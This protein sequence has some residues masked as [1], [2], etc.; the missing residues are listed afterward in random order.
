VQVR[1]RSGVPLSGHES[2]VP[3]RVPTPPTSLIGRERQVATLLEL[4]RPP[5]G[6]RL[7]VL[8]GPGGVGKTRLAL[9][10]AAKAAWLFADGVAYIP[11]A[12]IRDHALVAGAIAKAVGVRER[13]GKPLAEQ[14]A[15]RVGDQ[16]WLFVIDNFE[17]VV[18]AGPLLGE[19]LASCPRLTILVT[20][21]ARL[22]LSGEHDVP[23]PPL[24]LPSEG[25]SR[26]A[27]AR[28][29]RWP[30]SDGRLAIED[31]AGSA[32]VQLFVARAQ[33]V[34]PGFTLTADNAFAVAEICRQLDGLP[35]AIELAAARATVLAPAALLAR[36]DRRLSF[37]T[38]GPRDA[39]ARQ[40]TLRDAIAWSYD[41]LD[42]AEQT[43][44]RRVAIFAGGCSFETAARVSG[45]DSQGFT[46]PSPPS[47]TFALISSLVDKTMLQSI[48]E[49]GDEPRFVMLETIREYGLEQVEARGESEHTRRLH[50]EYFLSFAEAA[51]PKLRGREQAA[52][53]EA[54]EAEHDNLRAALA[55][56]LAA[57]ERAELALRLA[58]ALHWFWYLRGHFSEGRRWLEAALAGPAAAN[59]T[60]ARAKALV[61]AGMLA[62]RQ[63]D[64]PAARAR[65]QEGIAIG[66]D[67]QDLTSLTYAL[68]FLAMGTLLQDDHDALRSLIS[69]SVAMFRE[70][71][72]RW[73]LA[74]SLHA[75][76]MVAV[77]TLQ[78]DEAHTPF[79]ESQAL[80]RELQDTW[81]LARVLH[82]S[83]EMS[84]FRG[85]HTRA[86]AQ[87]EESLDLYREL[88]H[89][90]S[91]AIVLHNLGY[92][93]QHQD[94]LRRGLAYFAEALAMHVKHG[95]HTN[96]GHCLAGI[97]GMVGLLGQ[98]EQGARL[99]GAAASL[100][101]TV[102]VPIWPIDKVDYDR[103][104]AT[105]RARL[106]EEAFTAAFA[107]GQE[108]PL[109]QAI[110]DSFA[111]TEAVGVE[112]K[113]GGAVPAAVTAS[114]L[115]PRE[116][117]V[118]RLL[119]GRATDREIA[120]ELSISPRTVMHHVARIIA[121]LGVTNRRDAAALVAA[122]DGI[123]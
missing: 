103:N 93:A 118:L 81:G 35:L 38:D 122:G 101:E 61:G 16:N 12:S 26:K 85:D 18:D 86:Q 9:D 28:A 78:F 69:E 67:L 51:E 32:A 63:D 116:I 57:P 27:A 91:A 22:R 76:G 65:L 37:L 39:P 41:L 112:A 84:R 119:A 46:S 17:H 117:E 7:I 5:Q 47:D 55:W 107:L 43:L 114:G 71:G 53:L 99:F 82:Y 45:L 21:R 121:K 62:A 98:S 2:A 115:T 123:D 34:T 68:H 120:D 4:L 24:E 6:H 79:A 109:G 49:N 29:K 20:S 64:F 15:A 3:G 48:A 113:R 73:G 108:M 94:D 104:L 54:L 83:G 13:G 74:T 8:T 31:V 80:Y 111:V 96:I 75:L 52:Q 23:V 56:S 87:Y 40:R 25:G 92:V 105:V 66:R 59:R 30:Q 89:Q 100:L 42:P 1:T 33:A 97:A 19:L 50:A 90:F 77:V 14:I 72:D 70:S 10:V 60:P 88:G 11:L 110:A 36:L 58:G 44:F 106:G 102:G 95:D